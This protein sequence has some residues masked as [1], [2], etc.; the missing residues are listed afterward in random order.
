V[1]VR[2]ADQDETDAPTYAA[3]ALAAGAQGG[4]GGL[5]F[6][7]EDGQS[8]GPPDVMPRADGKGGQQEKAAD[9]RRDP[10]GRPPDIQRAATG[11][12]SGAGLVLK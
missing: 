12:I 1:I 11:F 5:I 7:E 10:E 2:A 8:K 9:A 3:H 6:K 4:A